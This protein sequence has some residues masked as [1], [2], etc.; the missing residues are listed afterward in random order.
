MRSGAEIIVCA[1]RTCTNPECA[2]LGKPINGKP[3]DYEGTLYTR[4]RGVLPVRITTL[5]CKSKPSLLAVLDIRTLIFR[6]TTA[7]KTTYRPN[8]LVH[9]ASSEHARREY[10]GG[11]PDVIEVTEHA[12]VERA[13]IELFRLQMAF[14]QYAA[15]YHLSLTLLY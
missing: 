7:C 2:E 14:S 6:Y 1:Q 3:K 13:L 8:Y 5:Y 12:Y 11:I 15:T 9:N 10:Y 4:R